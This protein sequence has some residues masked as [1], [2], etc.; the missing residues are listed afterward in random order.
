MTTKKEIDA[1][2]LLD[3]VLA[4]KEMRI[5]YFE[6]NFEAFFQYHF[7]WDGLK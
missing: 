3:E 2:K 1:E 4:D 5:A 7:G 6:H